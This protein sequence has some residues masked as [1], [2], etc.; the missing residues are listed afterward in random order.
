MSSR[1]RRP[2]ADVAPRAGSENVDVIR[3]TEPI[4]G[5]G[6]QGMQGPIPNSVAAG[7]TTGSRELGS[8]SLTSKPSDMP[9]PVSTR[10]YSAPTTVRA[11]ASQVNRIATAVL[12]G[13]VDLETARTYSSLARTVAQ[14]VTAETT[15]ARFI[16]KEPD[17][18]FE[19]EPGE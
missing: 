13:E 2:E 4:I 17:L 7:S 14:A 19:E 9:S 16:Q 15:R 18:T 3:S 1:R 12:N 5:F 10:R 11:F 6:L 8:A